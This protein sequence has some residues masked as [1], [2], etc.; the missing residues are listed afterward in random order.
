M[1]LIPES[2]LRIGR[3]PWPPRLKACAAPSTTAARIPSSP[4]MPNGIRI[5]QPLSRLLQQQEFLPLLSAPALL[6]SSPES[7]RPLK[8]AQLSSTCPTTKNFDGKNLKGHTCIDDIEIMRAKFTPRFFFARAHAMAAAPP[9]RLKYQI[10]V[11]T[12]HVHNIRRL[13]MIR[14]LRKGK[15]C[16]IGT[17][18]YA[19]T[20]PGSL[21]LP[22]NW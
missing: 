3:S 6:S 2:I 20:Q 5:R 18:W 15:T 16:R 8:R 7:T 9:P 10:G 14:L 13:S 12:A 22:K 11:N 21:S 19:S 17:V 4:T 1:I